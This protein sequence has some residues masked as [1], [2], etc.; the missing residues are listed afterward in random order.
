MRFYSDSKSQNRG[1]VVVQHTISRELF[2][3][4]IIGSTPGRKV[5]PCIAPFFVVCLVLTGQLLAFHASVNAAPQSVF[6][7]GLRRSDNRPQHN[8]NQLARAGIQRYAG[9]RLVLYTDIA[10]ELA[11]PLPKL[12]DELFEFQTRY[13]GPLPR[14][15]EGTEYQVTGYIM[16][17]RKKFQSLGLLPDDLPNFD[18]GRHLGYQFWMNDQQNDYYRRHLMLHEATHCF[19]TCETGRRNVP[20]VW[21]MEGMAE[22]CGTHFLKDGKARFGIFPHNKESF[23]G[24]GR[25]T[26]LQNTSRDG[27]L[28][29]VDRLLTMLP[30]DFKQSRHY[31]QSWA[32]CTFLNQHPRWSELFLKVAI[33]KTSAEFMR[34]FNTQLR[35][36]WNE[37]ATEFALFVQS[38]EDGFDIERSAINFVA[39]SRPT[40]GITQSIDA[41]R[42]W[43]SSRV[44]VEKGQQYQVTTTGRFSVAQKPRPWISEAQGISIR[45]A[46]GYPLGR[47]V[48][49][50]LDPAKQFASK[51]FSIGNASTFNAAGTG[52]LYLRL[53]DAWNALEDNKGS[54]S[55]TVKSAH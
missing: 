39:G 36:H 48:G 24:L 35:P 6:K 9:K 47:L 14:N 10:P 33:R 37:I 54:V 31:S 1:A 34:E 45:Y 55:V 15:R 30:A 53:N 23:A 29:T 20:P 49:R 21:F 46:N 43:Q 8:A 41:A 16:S 28:E 13:F 4:T 12:A 18:H 32:L 42:G 38:I 51:E 44:K 17:D 5:G 50:I 3:C 40:S 26:Q 27:E 7:S 52:T 2:S 25:I 11:R 19:M 22:W